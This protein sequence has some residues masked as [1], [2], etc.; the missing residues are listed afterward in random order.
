MSVSTTDRTV[1]YEMLL[2]IAAPFDL[3]VRQRQVLFGLSP[4]TQA[5]YRQSNPELGP[6]IADRLAR[7]QRLTD[8]ALQ[9]FEDEAEAKRWLSSPKDALDGLAPLE[10]MATDAGAT[11]VE[12]MLYRIEYGVYG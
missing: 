8:L 11:Q 10:A 12:Q 1:K 5:R 3:S 7:F 2:E 6:L 9:V 4:R